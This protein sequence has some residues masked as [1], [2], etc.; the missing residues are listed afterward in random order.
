MCHFVPF[1]GG[2]KRILKLHIMSMLGSGATLVNGGNR[3]MTQW[4][5]R[6]KQYVSGSTNTSLVAGVSNWSVEDLFVRAVLLALLHW[7]VSLLLAQLIRSPA[8]LRAFMFYFRCLLCSFVW[9][10]RFVSFLTIYLFA[11]FTRLFTQS[12]FEDCLKRIF[13]RIS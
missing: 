9:L 10:A 13:R 4:R 6:I 12:T 2:A 11:C 1:Q 3:N 7:V 5:P 8:R